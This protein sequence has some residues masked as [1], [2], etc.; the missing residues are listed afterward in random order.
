MDE[1]SYISM[2]ETN[3]RPIVNYEC[4]PKLGSSI[5]ITETMDQK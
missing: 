1:F 3:S 2:S 5:T 4:S